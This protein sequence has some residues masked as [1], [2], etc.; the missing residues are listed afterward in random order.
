MAKTEEE[1]KAEAL[2][3]QEAKEK[4]E[5]EK[6]A[7]A[8]AEEA[9]R[10]AK[11]NADAIANGSGGV[12][13]DAEI[14]AE[15][16]ILEAEMKKKMDEAKAGR[17]QA[18][19]GV[20]N[21]NSDKMYSGTDVQAMIK[22]ALASFKADMKAEKESEDD[23]D[24]EELFKTKKARLPRWKNK[25][26]VGFKN[27]NED[28]EFFPNLI[29]HAIDVWDDKT[30]QNIPTVACLFHDGSPELYVPLTTILKTAPKVWCDIVDIKRKDVSYSDGKVEKSDV[31]GYSIK[32]SGEYVKLKV[33]KEECRFILKL[34]DTGI[35]VEV[36]P[37]VINW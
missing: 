30:R 14:E 1:K 5:A 26:I 21:T 20:T 24:A 32:T 3:K 13:T 10:I 18:N 23:M 31:D 28:T 11:A 4:A 35:D 17:S 22:Q 37:E 12:K 34:P 6:K 25:F 16:K 15:S 36:G 33:K 8:D 7:L 27:Q 19:P 29:I 9:E 2:A